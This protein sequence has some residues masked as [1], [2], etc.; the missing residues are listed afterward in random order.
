VAALRTPAA[1][2]NGIYAVS[3]SA[4]TFRCGCGCGSIL[5]PLRPA[6]RSGA[7]PKRGSGLQTSPTS[8]QAA[9]PHIITPPRRPAPA[10]TGEFR[11][12]LQQPHGCPQRAEPHQRPLP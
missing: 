1:P 9:V 6:S 4:N 2:P 11:R 10:R 8:S 12:R 5:T 7:P 3:H